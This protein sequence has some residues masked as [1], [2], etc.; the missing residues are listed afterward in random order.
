MSALPYPKYSLG[1]LYLFPYHQ[2]REAY[3]IATG[4]KCPPW[5]PYRR[6]KY[7]FDPA[8]KESRSR[9]VTYDRAL[10]EPPTGPDGKPMLDVLVLD[11]EEASTVNIPPTGPGSTNT[12]G[13]AQ[14]EIPCP[15]RALELNEE[16][17]F[18]FGGIIVVKNKDLYQGLEVG[19]TSEDRTLLKAIA[20]KLG[21]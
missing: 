21:I 9:R 17:M 11:R 4:Q 6:P 10:A 12:P 1:K 16:L 15:L 7:W 3:E 20:T 8:A 18:D 13:A 2:T 19:F 14:P 5:N